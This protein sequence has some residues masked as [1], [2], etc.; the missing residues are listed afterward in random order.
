M[1][2]LFFNK[3]V[4]V[5]P[6]PQYYLSFKRPLLNKEKVNLNAGKVFPL[7]LPEM[8]AF[9]LTLLAL[10]STTTQ[11][12]LSNKNVF[13]RAIFLNKPGFHS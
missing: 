5:Q 12:V 1:E 3:N 7:S 10:K 4:V 13:T 8:P 6:Q 2:P 9:K 11:I